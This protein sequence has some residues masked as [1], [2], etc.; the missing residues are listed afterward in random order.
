MYVVAAAVGALGGWLGLAASYEASITYDLR[1]AS[2]R[3][4]GAGP[5]AIFVLVLAGGGGHGARSARPVA[6]G[7]RPRAGGG[8]THHRSAAT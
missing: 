5:R 4:G 8:R 1:L 7:H 6:D 2:G 3:D